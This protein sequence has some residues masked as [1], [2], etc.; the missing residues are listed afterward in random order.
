MNRCNHHLMPLLVGHIGVVQPIAVNH[1]DTWSLLMRQNQTKWA[2][3]SRGVLGAQT[4]PCCP[5]SSFVSR[6]S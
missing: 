2:E 5:T 4:A 3:A 6:D 1:D